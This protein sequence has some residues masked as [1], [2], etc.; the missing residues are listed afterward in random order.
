MFDVVGE[1]EHAF[2]VMAVEAGVG[3]DGET[4]EAEV[5][6]FE[7]EGGLKIGLPGFEGLTGEGEHEVDI[8][9]LE[10]GGLGGLYGLNDVG[11]GVDATELDEVVG[12]E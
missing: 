4:V 12:L 9:V 11:G 10:S 1:V 3:F 8:D 7:F 2:E 5:L 6:G